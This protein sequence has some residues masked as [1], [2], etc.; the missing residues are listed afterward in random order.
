[1]S[2]RL[3]ISSNQWSPD[4]QAM[5]AMQWLY[6]N[7]RVAFDAVNKVMPEYVNAR[8][9]GS[10]FDTTAMGVSDEWG[11]WLIDAIEDQS[12]IHWEDGEPWIGGDHDE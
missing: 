1:M 2:N 3:A 8:T 9:D 10:W 4:L 5:D 12:E 11:S 6:C 7:N